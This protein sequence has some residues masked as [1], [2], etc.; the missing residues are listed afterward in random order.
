MH[1][2]KCSQARLI[3]LVESSLKPQMPGAPEK[4]LR[5]TATTLW[6]SVHGICVLAVTGKL[7]WS[8]K[9]SAGEDA[10]SG[11]YLAVIST[12]GGGSVVRKLL[13]LR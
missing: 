12:P 5:R 11:G 10:A 8:G 3:E 2:Y 1:H 9:N 7:R 13:I 4:R 6:S